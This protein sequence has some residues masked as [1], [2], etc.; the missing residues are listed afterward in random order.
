[1][2][3]HRVSR[4]LLTTDEVQMLAPQL[5]IGHISG[6]GLR[7]FLFEKTGFD[8]NYKEDAVAVVSA[9]CRTGR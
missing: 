8:P 6:R 5:G 1:M 7:P 4:K 3:P 9:R 2:T